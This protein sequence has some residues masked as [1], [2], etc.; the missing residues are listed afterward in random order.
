MVRTITFFLVL[1]F[2]TYS[3]AQEVVVGN[4][5]CGSSIT[6]N[7]PV[8][9]DDGSWNSGKSNS[10][11]LMLYKGTE[12][13]VSGNLTTIGFY[14]DCGSKTYTTVSNQRIY[15]KETLDS[16]ITSSNAP[17]LSTFTKVF[18]G[19]ITWEKKTP[20]NAARN[21]IVLDTPFTYD[22]TKNLMIYFENESGIAIDLWGSISFL[23]SNQGNKR[24][25]YTLY[26]F[27]NKATSSGTIDSNLPVTYFKFSS[28][29][30]T[31][32]MPANESICA[33]EM[34]TFFGVVATDYNT[35]QWTS[36]G[37]GTFNNSTILNPTYT[38]SSADINAQSVVLTLTVMGSSSTSENFTLTIKSKP[39]ANIIKR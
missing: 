35:L 6:Q 23:W 10:W 34:F 30:P 16:E 9:Y 13:N 27:S 19:S 28:S 5:A 18:D 3:Y 15:I 37:S 22:K 38:P 36:S 31:I 20:Y 24:V 17:D 21:D 12:I 32:L 33:E 7:T 39:T 25:A 4:G 2:S 1:F 8:R 29:N 11:A 14:P 26:K